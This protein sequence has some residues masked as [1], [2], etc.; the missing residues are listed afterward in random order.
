MCFSPWLCD[1]CAALLACN[2][3][4][5]SAGLRALWYY[6]ATA[7]QISYTSSDIFW[8]THFQLQCLRFVQT[9]TAIGSAQQTLT[10]PSSLPSSSRRRTRSPPRMPLSL[11]P[12]A[13]LTPTGHDHHLAVRLHAAALTGVG[14][15]LPASS[16][17]T[18]LIGAGTTSIGF[19]P[20]PRVSSPL[21]PYSSCF[22]NRS[23]RHLI[24]WLQAAVVPSAARIA[25]EKTPNSLSRS[26]QHSKFDE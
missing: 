14:A 23:R 10:S 8:L 17:H 21:S 26:I 6:A 18:A 11:T 9:I 22:P 5:R 20:L 7:H 3:P 15:T 24:G 4:L 19:A 13:A 1:G 25:E 16:M 12:P 2:C